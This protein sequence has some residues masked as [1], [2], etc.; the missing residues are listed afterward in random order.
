MSGFYCA[1]F[2][3]QCCR[4]TIE[5]KII[6]KQNCKI[7]KKS[8]IQLCGRGKDR[9]EHCGRQREETQSRKVSDRGRSV[10]LFS[11]SRVADPDPAFI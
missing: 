7:L 10:S 1:E 2:T 4:M 11:V 8:A 9:G 6:G 5:I 3:P